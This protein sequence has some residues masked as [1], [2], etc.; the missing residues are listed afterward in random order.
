MS[1]TPS[2]F[3]EQL[4]SRDANDV[5][6]ADEEAA[7]EDAVEE[8]PPAVADASEELSRAALASAV[9]ALLASTPVPAASPMTAA[10]RR[11]MMAHRTSSNTE[12]PNAALPPLFLFLGPAAAP[13]PA[14]AAVAGLTWPCWR[15]EVVSSWLPL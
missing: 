3:E 13:A 9:L 5:L 10:D 8:P 6:V 14:P 1:V 4:S 12:Q 7:V 15:G 2:G 11:A